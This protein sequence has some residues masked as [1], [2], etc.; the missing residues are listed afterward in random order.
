M[1]P[2]L[3]ISLSVAAPT[4]VPGAVTLTPDPV[5]MALS[6]AT[7]SVTNSFTDRVFIDPIALALAVVAPSVSNVPP[8]SPFDDFRE[9][10]DALFAEAGDVVRH[11]T[12]TGAWTTLSAIVERGQPEIGRRVQSRRKPLYLTV[13]KTD[14]ATIGPKLDVVEVDGLEYVAARVESEDASATRFYCVR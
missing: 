4:I 3:A 6:V 2:A 11:R 13:S 12:S 8:R 10:L 5:A 9:D 1:N 7:P 14:L